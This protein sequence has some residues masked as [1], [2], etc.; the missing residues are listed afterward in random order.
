M[1]TQFGLSAGSDQG[2][3]DFHFWSY[4]PNMSHFLLAD[5]SARPLTYD[6]DFKLL[7]ALSTRAGGELA[8]VP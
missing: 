4:H 3:D 7:Q 6:I 8:E 5:G 1:S 2:A